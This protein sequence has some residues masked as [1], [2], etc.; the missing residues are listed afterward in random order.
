MKIA[1]LGTRGIP[2][3]YG[4]FETFAEELSARLVS[5][6]HDVTVYCR[7]HHTDKKL[8]SYKG[9]NLVV[10]PTIRHKYLDTVFHTFLSAVNAVFTRFDVVLFC[11]AANA[12]LIPILTWTGTP[13]AINVDGLERDRDKWNALGK[14]YYRLGERASVWF[15]THI[16]TDAAVIKDYYKDEYGVDSTMITYGAPIARET[17][18]IVPQKYGVQSNKYVL[19]LSRL[20]PENNADMVIEAFA[21]VKTEMKLLVVGDAPYSTEYKARLRALADKDPRVLFTGY[22]FGDDCKAL[23][24]NAYCYVHATEVGGTHPALLEG[25]GAGNCV[26]A[27]QT[28]ENVE[29]LGDAGLL[30]SNIDELAEKI[31]LTLDEPELV[32]RFGALAQQRIAAEYSWESVADEYEKLLSGLA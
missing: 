27:H 23:Q 18:E 16:V 11:N 21:K 15:A 24:Q 30:F 6:G 8:K 20:E 14:L 3:S 13:V 12:V 29:V 1:I 19:Y 5:R 4:G 17:S 10:L 28:P 25:M 22:V 7:S 9:V 26:I 31:R 2:A 32:K